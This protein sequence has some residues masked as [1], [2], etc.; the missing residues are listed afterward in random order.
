MDD[1]DDM[2]QSEFNQVEMWFGIVIGASIVMIVVL[3]ALCIIKI[4]HKKHVQSK[5][6]PPQEPFDIMTDYIN[7]QNYQVM[8]TYF[9]KL[10]HELYILHRYTFL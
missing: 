9:M 4:V 1:G 6:I 10:Q 8:R 3:C 5:E 2:N 7:A